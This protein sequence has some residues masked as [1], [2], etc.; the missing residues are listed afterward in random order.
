MNVSEFEQKLQTDNVMP[1]GPIRFEFVC[2]RSTSSFGLYLCIVTF[3][4]QI[5]EHWL[6]WDSRN[7]QRNDCVSCGREALATYLS[8]RRKGSWCW[9][10]YNRQSDGDFGF[11]WPSTVPDVHTRYISCHFQ[12]ECVREKIFLHDPDIRA[13]QLSKIDE[14]WT[15]CFGSG[16]FELERNRN[17][18]HNDLYCHPRQTSF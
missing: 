13:L 4:S 3:F 18:G 17:F 12:A 14:V 1:L 5:T 6:D 11:G 9:R 2:T 16:R 7:A 10:A 15:M 8:K